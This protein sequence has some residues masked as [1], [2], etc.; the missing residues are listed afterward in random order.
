M[1]EE[2]K[3]IRPRELKE[4]QH[5][6]SGSVYAQ[7]FL[8]ACNMLDEMYSSQSSHKY[9]MGD[10]ILAKRN[11]LKPTKRVRTNPNAIKSTTPHP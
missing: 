5:E 8:D 7:G 10:C 6:H 4:I 11:L 1:S 3:S 9:M 2:N